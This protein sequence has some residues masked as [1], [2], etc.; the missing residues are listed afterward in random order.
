MDDFVILRDVPKSETVENGVKKTVVRQTLSPHG[1]K[2]AQRLGKTTGAG[3]A[4]SKAAVSKPKHGGK[5]PKSTDLKQRIA[6]RLRAA[7]TAYDEN[8]SFVAR[9]LGVT[10]QVLNA[11]EKGR[12]YPDALM[13]IRFCLLTGCPTDWIFLGRMESRMPVTMAAR[14][15][16]LFP[17]LLRG[18]E[19]VE[20]VLAEA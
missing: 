17:Q 14:V 8:S 7:R 20:A 16:A 1:Q 19:A 9:E 12:N 11:A 18:A 3:D 5:Q 10:P 6:E 4:P 13:L 15:G 2:P